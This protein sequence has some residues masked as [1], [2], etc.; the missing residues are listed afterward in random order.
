MFGQIQAAGPHKVSVPWNP[1]PGM[2]Q[3]F[4]N[5]TAAAEAYVANLNTHT[6]YAAFRNERAALRDRGEALDGYRLVGQLLR[7]SELGLQ[8]V[9]FVRSVIRDEKLTDFDKARLSSF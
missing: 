1:G 3:P 5:V 4:T 6:A 7:Y 9:G 2:P 8:Y